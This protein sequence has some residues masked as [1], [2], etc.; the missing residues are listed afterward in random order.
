[1]TV[2]TLDRN[3]DY[4]TVHG[5]DTGGAAFEQDGFQFDYQ[6]N[7]IEELMSPEATK[8]YNKRLATVKAQE[9]AKAAYE[10]ALADSGMD[11]ND[12]DAPRMMGAPGDPPPAE[13]KVDLRA[14]FLGQAKYGWFEVSRAIKEDHGFAPTSKTNAAQALSEEF[15]IPL[16]SFKG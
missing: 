16:T 13:V 15:G 14:W 2:I 1:M 6:G 7:I 9:A 5:E 8:R 12:P 4:G 3:R 11:A 10:A